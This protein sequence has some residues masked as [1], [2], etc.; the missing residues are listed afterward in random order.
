MTAVILS[1]KRPWGRQKKK[2]KKIIINF[3]NSGTFWIK[4]SNGWG[5]AG[6][7]SQIKVQSK[8][9]TFCFDVW[10]EE[11]RGLATSGRTSDFCQCVI[12]PLRSHQCRM[13]IAE[14][15]CMR[16]C[17]CVYVDCVFKRCIQQEG[18]HQEMDSRAVC[19]HLD[20]INKGTLKRGILSLP[21]ALFLSLTGMSSGTNLHTSTPIGSLSFH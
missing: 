13:I 21:P 12:S 6:G 2:R 7:G 20:V 1:A 16:V 14:R 17:L 3:L 10:S 15:A 19:P 5:F 8:H 9:M 11:M 4:N 18:R